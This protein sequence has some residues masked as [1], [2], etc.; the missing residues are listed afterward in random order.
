MGLNPFGRSNSAIALD[1][2]SSF[3]KV[4]ELEE[5]KGKWSLTNFGM[6][7][8]P[9]EAIVDGALMN[10][11]II[12]DSIRELVTSNKIRTKDVVAS[13]SGHSVIIKKIN[14]FFIRAL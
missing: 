13:V 1:I 11:N 10:S 12:V 14:L 5:S 3:I 6:K 7:K 8:L 4:L 2:G 9:P